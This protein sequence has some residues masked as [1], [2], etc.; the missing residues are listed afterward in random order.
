M[1]HII[2]GL[3][4]LAST[5]PLMAASYT[6]ADFTVTLGASGPS[7]RLPFL[8]NGYAQSQ[9]FTGSFVFQ[10]DLVPA[11]G[12][13]NIFFDNFTDVADIPS[14]DLFKFNFGPLNFTEAD[15]ADALRL[16]GIQ[17]SGGAF[18]GFVFISD[19]LFM[20]DTYRFRSEGLS[21]NVRKL[22]G[23]NP[24]GSNLIVGTFGNYG[25]ERA[26]TIPVVTPPTPAVPEP[27]T[28]AMMIAGM[29]LTGAAMRARKSAVAFA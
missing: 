4:L 6:Q 23:G 19:F 11:S 15:N 14:A 28:W 27:A 18:N 16:A 20:G 29:G 2:L 22:I 3:A 13:T 8:G 5:S 25:N 10:N 7:V 1:K 12:L 21:F 26:Y 24:S 17:Y 9:Q